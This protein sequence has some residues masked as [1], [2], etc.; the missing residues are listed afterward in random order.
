MSSTITFPRAG[1]DAGI[2]IVDDEEPIRRSLARLL[3]RSGY[4]CTTA[5]NGTEARQ[6]LARGSFDLMLCDVTMP[7]ESGFTL[8]AHVHA[9]Y[10]D[11][12]VIMV[13][14]IDSPHTAEPANRFGAYGYILKPFDTNVI[15]INVVGALRQRDERIAARSTNSQ[16]ETDNANRVAEVRDLLDLLD[17]EDRA[18]SSS[19][20]ET[21][22][23]AAIAAEWRDPET[24]SHLH[25]ISTHSAR[26]A[27]LSGLATDEVETLRIASQLHDVGKVAIPE[28][29]LSKSRL[30][31]EE[32]RLIMQG[33]T[34]TG[35][36]MLEGAE[37]PV[38]RV[39]SIVAL[40]HHER[41][42]GNGYPHGLVG[43]AIPLEGR[44]VAIA[45]VY[46]ALRSKR[47]YKRAYSQAES[48]ETLRQRRRA[49]LDPELLDLFI[50]D[51][52]NSTQQLVNMRQL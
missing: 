42:D 49:Q 18:R 8:L 46:D 12:A 44:I 30:L 24:A 17:E 47:P 26:L 15:L 6:L 51:L 52:E 41:F 10:P 4:V 23:R 25:R 32:E 7:G 19:R 35:F 28:A 2:L 22:R 20:E 5:S 1:S 11:M 50:S 9:A 40:S 14:A 45:D 37:S 29:I 33:H 27:I 36:K 43:D 48:L 21:A 34:E 13:T 31:S 39:G 38:R 16:S 3:E